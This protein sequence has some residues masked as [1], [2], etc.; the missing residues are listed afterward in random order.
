MLKKS[1]VIILTFILGTAIG[2]AAPI[3]QHLID[4]TP[5]EGL[6]INPEQFF[7]ANPAKTPV[8][9]DKLF[10]SPR[11]VVNLA[12]VAGPFVGRHIH[13]ETDELIY[14]LKGK[15]EV[16]LNG[17]WVL[18]K[19]GDF[20]ICPRGIAHTTRAIDKEGF[21]AIAIFTKPVANDKVMVDD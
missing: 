13:T 5:G 20:H 10:S 18:M 15:G 7:A 12:R 16:Y 19:A 17:K 1:F 2:L 3:A 14:V 21:Q 11:T 6:L 9:F 4:G 8:Q